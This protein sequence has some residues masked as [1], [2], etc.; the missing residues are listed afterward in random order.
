MTLRE[1][2]M[3]P[4]LVNSDYSRDAAERGDVINVPIPSAVSVIDVTPSNT[5]PAPSNSSFDTVQISLDQWKQNQ[6]FGLSDKDLVEVDRN[7]HFVPMKVEEAIKA[8]AND[9]NED[10]HEKYVGIY[11]YTGTA[12]TT[13]FGS[14]I[15]E[16]A[17]MRKVLNEQLAP[18]RDR[19]IVLDHAAEANAVIR[20]E[21]SDVD[22]SS[23]RGPIIE[24]MIGRKLGFDWYAD[25][26]VMTH[27]AGTLTGDP[28][29]TTTGALGAKQISLTCDSDDE[30]A[31]LE[32][33]I[34]TFAGDSQ[35]YA[36]TADLT[37]GN[38]AAGILNIE[39]GL[40]VAQ[41]GGEAI[42][43]K[44]SHVVNLAFHRDAFAYATRPLLANTQGFNF[45]SQIASQMDPV[46]GL[47]LR[48]E[49]KRLHKQVV[50]EFDILWG[51][52]LVRPE[53][54]VR[55]AG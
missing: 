21:F 31:L 42:A 15:T 17:Q 25:D 26:A 46:T 22:R 50:W 33:D 45:A 39:P 43:V 24:G 13:P 47:V 2:A 36:V 11:G 6:P 40:A 4:Q 53:L 52:Q 51:S 1:M 44:A 32:G 23:D 5:H 27:T 3:M 30:I 7:E 35:T 28:V 14:G 41:A 48:L 8:L 20:P 38:S 49:V 19:R 55:L 18:R 9:V 16:A 37:V 34:V 54:A 29:T 12:A 10:I